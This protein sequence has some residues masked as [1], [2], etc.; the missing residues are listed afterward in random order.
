MKVVELKHETFLSSFEDIL[1]LE[2][3]ITTTK[4]TSHN[5][6][7]NL[8]TLNKCIIYELSNHHNHKSSVSTMN[9]RSAA[10]IVV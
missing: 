8:K 6:T 2:E 9:I 7:N 4:R 3:F 1:V 5:I 10:P